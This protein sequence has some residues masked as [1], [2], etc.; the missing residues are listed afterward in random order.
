MKAN[1]LMYDPGVKVAPPAL[2]TTANIAKPPRKRRTVNQGDHLNERVTG[3]K[4]KHEPGEQEE[5]AEWLL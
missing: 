3:N 2:A 1:I 4:I 5:A